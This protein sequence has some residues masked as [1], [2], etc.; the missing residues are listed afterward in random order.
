[1]YTYIL[2]TRKEKWTKKENKGSLS[3][4]S[5]MKAPAKKTRADRTNI[6]P[7]HHKRKK[8]IRKGGGTMTR[9]SQP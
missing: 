4:F 3:V 2:W 5:L 1:M 7:L 8:N 9:Y 6:H